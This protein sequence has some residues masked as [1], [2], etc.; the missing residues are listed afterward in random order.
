MCNKAVDSYP[1][2]IQFI[3]EG[4]KTEKTCFKTGDTNLFVFNYIPHQ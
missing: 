4:Y 1:S 2:P 3:P